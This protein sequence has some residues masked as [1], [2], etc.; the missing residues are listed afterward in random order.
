MSADN[1][2]FQN[3]VIEVKKINEIIRCRINRNF[4]SSSKM[5]I[6]ALM[7]ACALLQIFANG[8]SVRVDAAGVIDN[9]D[10]GAGYTSVLYD[11][12]NGLPT[13]EANA[14]VQSSDGF[15][16]IGGYSGLI[17]Y[18]GNTFYRYDS[19]TGVSS[20]VCLFVDS[21]ER[22]WIGTNDNGVA[23]LKDEK[24]VFYN[25]IGGL[26]SASVRSIAEDN[27]GNIIIAT[28]MG[29]AYIDTSDE[30]HT[31]NDPQVNKEYIYKLVPDNH[32][33]IYGVTLSGA[34]FT[35]ENKRVSGYYGA[36]STGISDVE[37]ICPDPENPGYIYVG[38]QETKIFYGNIDESMKD[39]VVISVAPHHTINAL[40]SISGRIWVCTDN[41][42]GYFE[43]DMKYVQ[44]ENLQLTNSIDSVM[45]DY[46]GSLWFTS[47]RQGVMKIVVNQFTDISKVASLDPMVVNSTCKYK[48]DLYLG[49]DSGLIILD[50]KN[51]FS[52]KTTKMTELLNGVRIRCIQLDS[53]GK[54]WMCT[55]SDNGLIC[56]DP[57]KDEYTALNEE[58]GM[59]SN[60]VRMVKELSDGRIA[61]ATNAG[62]NIIDNGKVSATFNSKD[63]ISNLEILSIEEG[64]NGILYVGS[65]G[66]GI[67]KI[68]GKK[69]SRL[70][71]NDG[72]RSEV[73][74]RIKKDPAQ[75]MFWII[76][77]NSIA[78]MTDDKITTINNFPYSNNFDI[79]FDD[80]N[81]VWILSSNGIYV[82]KR[83]NLIADQNIDFQL[84]DTKSSLPRV[85]TANSYSFY[86]TDGTLYLSAASGVCS[87]NINNEEN[88]NKKIKLGVPF[89]TVDDSYISTREQKEIH[90]PANSKRLNIYANAFTYSLNNPHLRYYL[91]GFDDDPIEI[92]KQDLDYITYT[93]L[94]G[95][96][97]KFHLSIVDTMTGKEDQSI[98]VTIIK[99]M[100]VYEMMWFRVVIVVLIVLFV[101]AIII[102]YFRIKTKRLLAKQEENK[103]L[104]NEITQ[105][106]ATC[107]DKKDAYTNGHSF[108]VAKY[109]Q[110]IAEKLGKSKAELE[111]IYNI[112]L[113][114]DIGKITIPNN[115]LNK[116]GR[117]TDDEY[118][119]MKTHSTNG[120]EIL[121]GITIAPGIASGAHSH[122]ER[123]DGT[124][125]PEKLK[126]DEIPEV[127][128]I[129]A[130]AD[131]FD[132]M[133]STRPYRKK[134]KLEKAV[135][136]IKRCSGT[137]F[138]PKMVEAFLK[139]V[140]EGAFDEEEHAIEVTEENQAKPDVEKKP[141]DEKKTDNDKKSDNK[142]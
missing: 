15:I 79:H 128:Q 137:Q 107:V 19:S 104:I 3:M 80:L 115:I 129:I 45:E 100:A 44:I 112:A 16:W 93:N 13:S 113:L 5:L 123:Y 56:Y 98:E 83:E 21:K 114:H 41:G 126:G 28:T 71:V 76:T 101:A 36:E 37:S 131:A 39:P 23:M 102:I 135:A 94:R 81:R 69:V 116:P 67:Y 42:I 85:S 117:L 60:R 49:T 139:L 4:I 66:D 55:Y 89:I 90:I 62:V 142:S 17:R 95:G 58:K 132:A 47:S 57:E 50:I 46:E 91:D 11:N 82:V 8:G 97:Y 9:I 109:T 99:D 118:T 105:A 138:N 2:K 64:S 110:M 92:H 33:K 61:A 73:I 130:V 70:G 31:I 125:Y 88:N 59:A 65:D 22:L 134:M 133:Y 68:D 77:S 108:R 34:F 35:V 87:V 48:D 18:D 29:L 40:S 1:I 74:L 127:A 20:V 96:T 38:A 52:K 141:D 63:G 111:N 121:K 72:L 106:F 75:D 103:K 10:Y 54:L 25:K 124:G 119:I 86:D 6:P 14:I 140:D 122:H 120:Y 27:E 12:T 84:Y 78:R 53:K 7:I 32:G 30:L 26:K 24:F 136:E 51:N 43:K